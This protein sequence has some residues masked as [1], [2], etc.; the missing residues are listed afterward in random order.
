[1]Q[2]AVD[3]KAH[4]A[5]LAAWFDV[6]IAGALLEGVLEQPVDDIDDVRVVGVR[7]LIL[8]AEAQQLLE[9]ANAAD[10][11]VG[12]IGAADRTRQAIELGGEALNIA[13]VGHHTLDWALEHMHQVGFPTAYQRLAAGDGDAFTVHCHGENL[14]A[15][16]EGVGH[17]RGDG[18]YVDLQ[19]VDAQIGLASE[20]GQPDGKGFQVEFLAGA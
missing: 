1:M 17:Q 3:A 15:L 5:L 18:R 19:R 10:L 9:I 2:H 16:G 12:G 4:R 6:D 7:L 11:L 8:G 20:V 14:V 13:W